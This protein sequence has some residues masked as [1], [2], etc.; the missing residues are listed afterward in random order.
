MIRPRAG[1]PRDR[2]ARPLED[3]LVRP[4][5]VDDQR[6][7]ATGEE[8]VVGQRLDPDPQPGERGREVGGGPAVVADRDQQVPARGRMTD[9][10][11]VAAV[12][13]S[14]REGVA[15]V[16]EGT[17]QPPDVSVECPALEEHRQRPLLQGGRRPGSRLESREEWSAV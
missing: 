9:L 1:H 6:V 5:Q 16:G 17:A 7:V 13:Q 8:S 2:P 4:T 12:G 10:E 14:T 15:P 3:R 11:P